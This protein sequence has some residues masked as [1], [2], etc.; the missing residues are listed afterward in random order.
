MRGFRFLVSSVSDRWSWPWGFPP[1]FPLRLPNQRIRPLRRSLFL[2]VF[3]FL[4]SLPSPRP[5]RFAI[6]LRGPGPL[7]TGCAG[8]GDALLTSPDTGPA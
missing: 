7:L 4:R 2:R 5:T 3:L 1:P 6:R 8:A